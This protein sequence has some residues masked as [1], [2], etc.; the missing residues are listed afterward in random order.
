[1]SI[2]ADTMIKGDGTFENGRIRKFY[3]TSRK[4]IDGM[5]ELLLKIGYSTTISEYKNTGFSKNKIYHLNI[6]Q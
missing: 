6:S 2:F 1:L 4:L 5:Q 3:S